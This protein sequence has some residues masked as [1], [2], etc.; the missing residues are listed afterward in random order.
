MAILKYYVTEHEHITTANKYY[1]RH[2]LGNSDK[3]KAG[4]VMRATESET[5]ELMGLP[6]MQRE[7]PAKA[8]KS[9]PE[10]TE[11]GQATGT[12]EPAPVKVQK[13]VST[14]AI[15]FALD[16][17]LEFIACCKNEDIKKEY[18]AMKSKWVC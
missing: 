8:Q 11:A 2:C 14:K 4:K 6:L 3:S 9:L 10:N 17:C 1:Y 12:S 16:R 5:M 18:E 13:H 7:E 15:R